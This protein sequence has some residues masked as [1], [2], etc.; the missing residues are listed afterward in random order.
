M[1]AEFGDDVM[2][3]HLQ[4]LDIDQD[5]KVSLVE[6]WASESYIDIDQWEGLCEEYDQMDANHDRNLD[7]DELVNW[8]HSQRTSEMEG[9]G[10][11]GRAEKS[12]KNKEIG[13][14]SSGYL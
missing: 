6:F 8:I 10:P 14:G 9:E 4:A 5:S 11:G 13:L 7:A 2:K 12:K 3:D 1:W